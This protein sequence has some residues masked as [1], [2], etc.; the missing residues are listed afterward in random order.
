MNESACTTYN[1]IQQQ[2]QHLAFEKQ[3]FF[4]LVWFDCCTWMA[5]NSDTDC[6]KILE[7]HM[8]C[9]N[10]LYVQYDVFLSPNTR[11]PNITFHVCINVIY[12]MHICL[13]VNVREYEC[14]KD[15]YCEN[16]VCFT[17]AMHPIGYNCCNFKLIRLI[18]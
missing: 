1:R 9:M 17:T 5:L 13:L 12:S 10:I 3:F 18:E 7:M 16:K 2:Q 15:S 11:Y 8:Y 6:M 4:Y 14:A